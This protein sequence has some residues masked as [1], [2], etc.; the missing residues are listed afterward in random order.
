METPRPGFELYFITTVQRAFMFLIYT[1]SYTNKT[2]FWCE[3]VKRRGE[4]SLAL[5][6]TSAPA[7]PMSELSDI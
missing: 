6:I 2:W 3:L 1:P 7:F 4:W 5:V